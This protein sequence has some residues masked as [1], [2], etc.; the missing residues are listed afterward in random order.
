[1][2]KP[3]VLRAQTERLL[4][5]CKSR[6]F[7]DAFLDYWLDLRRI[8][9]TAPDAELYSDYYLDDLLTESALEETR[10]FFAELLRADLPAGNV[11]SSDFAMLN[12]TLA[13]HYRLPPVQGVTVRRTPLPKE[14]V[15]GGLITQAAVLKVTANGTTTS[16]VLRGAWIMERILGQKPPPPPPSVPAVD[17][18]IRGAVTIRQQLEKH[19]TQESCNVCHAKID[20]AGFALENFDV[21]GGWRERYRSEAGGEPAQGIAKSGQ[22]FSFHYALAVDASGELPD[23]RTFRDIREFKQLLLADEKQ[24]ARNLAKQFAVYAIGAPIRFADRQQIEQI[25][26]RASSSHY[27]VRSI[28]HELV[29]SELF[30]RK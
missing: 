17:P 10:S 26:D 4:N 1:L 6:Q 30:L 11:V 15:R 9:T 20:P 22:K 27:G 23:G 3:E 5:D 25:I 19:R 18:D 21:M 12:E 24:L 14:S 28:V 8:L 13:A 7:V 16:P 29:Q 2:H